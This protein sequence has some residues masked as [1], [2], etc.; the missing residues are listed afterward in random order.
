VPIVP[1]LRRSVE[2]EA[3]AERSRR[4]IG[5]PIKIK[6]AARRRRARHAHRAQRAVAHDRF[7]LARSEAQAAFGDGHGVLRE[8]RREPASHRSADPGDKHG[9]VLH[10]GERD[11]SIQRRHQ[12]LIEES[13]SPALTPEL[14]DRICRAAVKVAMAANYTNAGTVEFLLA[15]D[16]SFYFI[17]VNARIQVEHTVTELVTGLDLIQQQLLIA[18]GERLAFASRTSSRAGHAIEC[19]INA[20]DPEKDFQ[21]SPGRSSSS[22]RRADRVC[23]STATATVVTAFRRTTTR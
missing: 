20:E 23:A 13:P 11:C 18:S 8:V 5:Y 15:R 12:K 17:E 3:K 2:D 1:G 22:C 19:R 14:R 6:A 9:K 21:P 7:P 16:G 4:Q 10:L